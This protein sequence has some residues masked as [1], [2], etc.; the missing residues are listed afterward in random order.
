MN[1]ARAVLHGRYH[2]DELDAEC[3]IVGGH[4]RLSSPP[5][6]PMLAIV[7]LEGEK[8]MNEKEEEKKAAG[9]SRLSA[10][11]GY[12]TIRPLAFAACAGGRRAKKGKHIAAPDGRITKQTP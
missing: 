9:D 10:P 7:P 12:Y 4:R 1:K 3:G 2:H 5:P 8:K 6:S 11:V